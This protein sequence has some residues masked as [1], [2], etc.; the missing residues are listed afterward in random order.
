MRICLLIVATLWTGVVLVP[1]ARCAEPAA[2]VQSPLSPQDSLRQL[3][4]ADDDLAVELAA[5]EP[6][7]IDP[8]AIKFDE[9]SRMWVAEMHDYPLGALQTGGGKR[10]EKDAEPMSRIKILEDADGDGRFEKATLFA[11]KLSFVTGIQPWKG[12]VIVTLA[13][14]VAYM[15]DTDGD[16]KADLDET[17]FTGFAEQNAQ[18]RANHPTF[19]LDNWIYVANGLRGGKVVNHL[20]AIRSQEPGVRSQESGV[21]S[22]I[23]NLKSEI[24]LSGMDFRFNPLTGEAEAVSGNGQF[25]L[26]FDDWGNRFICS[27][28]NPCMHVVI[29]NRYLKRAPNVAIPAVVQDVAAAA[30]NSR[31]YPLTRAWTTS[32]LHAGQFT[33]ACGVFI[34]RGDLLPSLRGNVFTCDPTGNLVHREIMKE[35]GPTFES[36]PAYDGKEFLASRDEWFRPV[37]MQL[38]PDGALY[39]VDMYRAVIE[40]PEWVPDELKNRP[41]ERLGDDR[42]RIYRIVPKSGVPKDRRAAPKLSKAASGELVNLLERENAWQRET[43]QRL[44]IERCDQAVVGQLGSIAM[45]SVSP[46]ARVEAAWTMA[47]LGKTPWKP[48]AAF[49]ASRNE[50]ARRAGVVLADAL[51]VA[52]PVS[53][54]RLD[55][56]DLLAANLTHQ[57]PAVRFHAMQA[58]LLVAPPTALAITELAIGD[59]ADPWMRRAFLLGGY[60]T[61]KSL[62]KLFDLRDDKI[63]TTGAS[64]L[65]LIREY[66]LQ[67]GSVESPLEEAALRVLST[68]L[69][70]ETK[71]TVGL[72][73][74]EAMA[75]GF[76]RRRISLMERL[77]TV[78]LD[79]ESTSQI[80]SA[81]VATAMN[82]QDTEQNRLVAIGLLKFL[83]PSAKA[84]EDLAAS[85]D[86]SIRAEAIKSLASH[87]EA[88]G[89]WRDLIGNYS[90]QPPA[91]RPAIFDAVLQRSERI[92]LLLDAIEAGTIQPGE[93][94]RVQTDRLL[95]HGDA[96]IRERAERIFGSATPADRQKALEDYQSVLTMK[97]DATRGKQV[98]AKNCAT[99]HKVGDIGVNV[100]PDISD[101]RTKT[102]AQVLGDIIQPNRAIDANYIAWN[103]LLA[104]GSSASG[105]LSAETGTS[106]TLRQPEGKTL[107]VSRS[108]IEQLKSSGLSLMPE[109]LEKNIPHQEMADLI[110]F[111]KNWRYLDGLTPLNK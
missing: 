19:A 24:S 28:R 6:E 32:N 18:L 22:E 46:Y 21:K 92:P 1:L 98:F 95:K 105:V 36:K 79:Q 64:R 50:L 76:S 72:V 69:L 89:T 111:I 34:Y 91:I 74:L 2:P 78:G 108:D 101:S 103:V 88:L 71:K 63:R 54:D 99:C 104:D 11:D 110:S 86:D 77:S 45:E 73:G 80:V 4:L 68:A 57:T 100:A 5:A 83:P 47:G 40:H 60:G 85:G 75:R 48:A 96:K 52:E 16:G 106:I 81:T 61:E 90:A 10:T 41:D 65:E 31:I 43:A 7:V 9:D 29:E 97:A 38:G 84:L 67:L 87:G 35:K 58:H 59:S 30:E 33:A 51:I 8:V 13:G 66:A 14:K 55:V 39:V 12:G 23:P 70:S 17:W 107:L 102:P 25:G 56:V 20:A 26:T 53:D 44:L 37:S 93:I 82:T 109:G 42:G 49:L 94:D 62:E 27:N 15:K 3:V